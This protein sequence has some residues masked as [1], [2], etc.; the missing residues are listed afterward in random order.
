MAPSPLELKTSTSEAF[1]ITM[2]FPEN[3]PLDVRV[4]SPSIWRAY[5]EPL[6]RTTPV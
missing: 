6:L 3:E 1:S 2:A 4:M 5:A